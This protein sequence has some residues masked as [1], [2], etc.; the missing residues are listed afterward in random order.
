[1]QEKGIVSGFE[2]NTFRP[3]EFL[4]REQFITMAV[5]GL[6]LDNPLS[7]INFEDSLDRWSYEFIKIAGNAMVDTD[8]VSFRPTELAL[9]EDVAMAMVKL[10]N[11][12]DAE[13]N[14]DLLNNFSDKEN[15][16]EARKKYVAIAVENG[17]MSGNDDGTFCPDKALSRA[18]GATVIFN[19][20][21]KI[22]NSEEESAV[23][24]DGEYISNIDGLTR[25]KLTKISDSEV[26]FYIKGVKGS[27][28]GANQ[29]ATITD[30]T[31]VYTDF[32]DESIKIEFKFE[33]SNLVIETS[34]KEGYEVFAGTYKI[35]DGT[36]STIERTIEKNLLEGTYLLGEKIESPEVENFEELETFLETT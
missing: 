15:I 28:F 14:L 10:N 1:M 5:K 36:T 22:E 13:Y 11:L 34:G 29:I 33:N 4:T 21:N 12:E 24:W 27:S 7:T 16:S 35:D 32:F 3:N 19:M 18:E 9:R 25:V 17:F 2:D 30:D 6:E 31:A 23:N 8:D 20:L 26:N